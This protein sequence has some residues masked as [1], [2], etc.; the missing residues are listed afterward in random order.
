[1]HILPRAQRL[2]ECPAFARVLRQVQQVHYEEW[3][4]FIDPTVPGMPETLPCAG[5]LVL[6][7]AAPPRHIGH[8]QRRLALALAALS[9][10][11]QQT[12]LVCLPL[13]RGASWHGSADAPVHAPLQRARRQAV[14]RQLPDGFDGAL[15]LAPDEVPALMPLWFWSERCGAVQGGIVFTW[16]HEPVFG[17]LCVHGSLHLDVYNT[18]LFQRLQ[19]QAPGSGWAP[20]HGTCVEPFGPGGRIT[21][22]ALQV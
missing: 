1:M 17:Q 18:T 10:A 6:G 4:E 19:A 9:H 13:A 14:S 22:R 16:G 7:L 20:V 8:F 2:Q 11:V 3:P 5:T 21:G 15:V 12:T